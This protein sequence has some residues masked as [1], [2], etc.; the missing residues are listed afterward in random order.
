MARTRVNNKIIFQPVLV[1]IKYQV[2]TVPEDVIFNR[3]ITVNIDCP[4][5]RLGT[6]EIIRGMD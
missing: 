3:S 4:I 5:I 6:K 2:Y 1:K